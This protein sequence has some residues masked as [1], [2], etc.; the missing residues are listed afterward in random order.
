[1]SGKTGP[2]VANSST[3]FDRILNT[4]ERTSV[5]S[6]GNPGY[7]PS[8]CEILI[9]LCDRYLSSDDETTFWRII[10]V[11]QATEAFS[12]EGLR[13]GDPMRTEHE[14]WLKSVIDDCCGEI[15]SERAI[16]LS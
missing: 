2:S 5:K 14:R 9:K 15:G 7:V 10:R 11:P 1:M 3:R 8:H 13:R 16:P 4:G 6:G 12:G